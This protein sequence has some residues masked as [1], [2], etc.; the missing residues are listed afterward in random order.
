MHGRG[1][2]PI[3]LDW[4]IHIWLV[5]KRRDD[6]G[7]LYVPPLWI[8]SLVLAYLI[9]ARFNAARLHESVPGVNLDDD[10]AKIGNTWL[11]IEV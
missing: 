6:A 3:V 7:F 8:C 1:V 10:K 11:V 2:K 5:Y 4:L 9:A